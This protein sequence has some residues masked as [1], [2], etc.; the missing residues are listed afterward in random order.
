MG[1]NP[2]LTSKNSSEHW[3]A[4]GFYK[5]GRVVRWAATIEF[6]SLRYYQI[7]S[8]T[9]LDRVSVF[10]TESRRFESVR[11][12]HRINIGMF[13]QNKKILACYYMGSRGD[14][15]LSILGD[16]LDKSYQTPAVKRPF[17][18]PWRGIKMHNFGDVHYGNAHDRVDCADD[19]LKYNSIRISFDN[20][21]DALFSSYMKSV[22][23]AENPKSYDYRS[24]E[25]VGYV[26]GHYSFEFNFRPLNDKF[27]EVVPFPK[28]FDADFL[29]DL[30]ERSN[31]K[32]INNS[33]VGQ[34][35]YNIAINEAYRK[36]CQEYFTDNNLGRL[37]ASYNQERRDYNYYALPPIKYLDNIDLSQADWN[38]LQ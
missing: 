31:G 2:T 36:E 19:L 35:Q 37:I 6:E 27:I 26:I 20:F 9:Q 4:A 17:N 33:V 14:F 8:L 25:F 10:E 16:Y 30:Y 12:G 18:L 22:K 32:T 24:T 15:L 11:A 21:Q 34:I 28:M 7:R 38:D 3:Y 23:H 5:P 29:V 1:S 13:D